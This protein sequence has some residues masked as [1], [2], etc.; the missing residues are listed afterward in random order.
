VSALALAAPATRLQPGLEVGTPGVLGSLA[1]RPGDRRRPEAGEVEVEVC[2]AGL[3]FKDVLLAL[4]F[5][6][7]PATARVRLGSECAGRVAALGEGVEGLAVGDEVV[8]FG[9]G[10]FAPYAICPAGLVLK[11]PEHLSFVEAATIPVAFSTACVALL[12]LARL[13]RGERLLVHAAAGG[14]GMA[15][16]QVA[17]RIGAVVFATAGSEEKRDFLRS[18]GIEHVFDS[19]SLRFADEVMKWTSGHGVDVVLNSLA[20]DFIPRSLSVLAPHGRF[21]EIGKRDIYA[22]TA[23]GMRHFERG[24]SFIAVNLD[25]SRGGFGTVWRRVVRRFADRSFE[26][27]PHRVFPLD[28]AAAA[29]QY[30]AEARHIGKVV[31]AVAA[32]E[33]R[34]YGA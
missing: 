21:L 13:R 31:L 33:G 5:I 7:L 19:R 18:L 3:N 16:V 24:L 28:Q 20:G 9:Y 34:R 25:W 11:K 4:G 15:A 14:V 27:L 17:R 26:P 10:C 29:F 32:A 30:M 2:A 1:L 23:L 22:N 6:P 12:E 8:S